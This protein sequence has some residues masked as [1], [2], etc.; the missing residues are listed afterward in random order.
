MIVIRFIFRVLIYIWFYENDKFI[1]HPFLV[2]MKSGLYISKKKA[3]KKKI[4]PPML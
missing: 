1:S 2:T 3:F 4:K